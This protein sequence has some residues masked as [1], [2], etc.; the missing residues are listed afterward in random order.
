MAAWNVRVTGTHTG[1]MMG[2][3]ATGRSMFQFLT[4]IG[5]LPPPPSA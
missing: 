5:A 4:Q 3:A 2:I 1:D